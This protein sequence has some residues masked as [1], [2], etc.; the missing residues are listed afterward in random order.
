MLLRLI[1]TNRITVIPAMVTIERLRKTKLTCCAAFNFKTAALVSAALLITSLIWLNVDFI[2]I[3]LPDRLAM[4][5]Y[6]NGFSA[7]LTSFL[8]LFIFAFAV[9]FN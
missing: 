2:E 8:R 5:D 1:I 6:E 7:A 9:C 4:E 3:V